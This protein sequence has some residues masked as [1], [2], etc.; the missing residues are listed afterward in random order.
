MNKVIIRIEKMSEL[1]HNCELCLT[2]VAEYKI[3][4]STSTNVLY[5]CSLHTEEDIVKYLCRI[6]FDV[7]NSDNIS[8][9]GE[10]ENND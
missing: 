4:V 8:V 10:I 7:R 9:I 2:T 3:T 6:D 1:S 5:V